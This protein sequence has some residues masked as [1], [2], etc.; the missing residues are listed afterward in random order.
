MDFRHIYSHF[1]ICVSIVIFS[2]NWVLKQPA[3][4]SICQ[5]SNL[6][7]TRTN[8]CLEKLHP[9]PRYLFYT[10]HYSV[11]WISVLDFLFWKLHLKKATN[12]VGREAGVVILDAFFRFRQLALAYIPLTQ[13]SSPRGLS[14]EI[15]VIILG[16]ATLLLHFS[17]I[18]PTFIVLCDVWIKTATIWYPI[19]FYFVSYRNRII[20]PRSDCTRLRSSTPYT[21][22]RTFAHC[23]VEK[24]CPHSEDHHHFDSHLYPTRNSFSSET[25]SG[26]FS[27]LHHIF[28]TYCT[29]CILSITGIE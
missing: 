8:L 26:L 21:R 17:Y 5:V 28:V 10:L 25:S 16:F 6:D 14:T 24:A 13:H 12:C 20:F 7:S 18:S 27:P 23:T 4:S 2:C 11:S 3:F 29:G 1:V 9:W 15:L 22:P 19:G